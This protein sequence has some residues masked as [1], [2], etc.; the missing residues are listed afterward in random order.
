MAGLQLRLGGIQVTALV[1]VTSLWD[2]D[3][4]AM[5]LILERV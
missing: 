4:T 1:T 2:Y 5:S 3:F